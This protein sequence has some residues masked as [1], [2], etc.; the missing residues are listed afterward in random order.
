M[1]TYYVFNYAKVK[2]AEQ[3]LPQRI[4]QGAFDFKTHQKNIR[5]T[6]LPLSNIQNKTLTETRPVL[7]L[8]T[9]FAEE[10]NELRIL[11]ENEAEFHSTAAG[12]IHNYLAQYDNE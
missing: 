7:I 2:L 10:D 3:L 4:G 12:E 8:E 11:A 5:Q 1:K 9:D 6:A